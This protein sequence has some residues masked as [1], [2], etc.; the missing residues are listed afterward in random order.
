MRLSIVCLTW[1][2]YGEKVGR[3][4]PS[5]IGHEQAFAHICQIVYVVRNLY[6]V[7]NYIVH[8]HGIGY[9]YKL[10]L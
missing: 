7:C 4:S 2:P 9:V 6:C 3:L 1:G 5:E 10:M 8:A